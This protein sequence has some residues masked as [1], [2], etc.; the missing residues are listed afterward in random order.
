[1]SLIDAFRFKTSAYAA[2]NSEIPSVYDL[3]CQFTYFVKA[4]IVNIYSK[5]LTD[6]IQRTQGIS[7]K[8]ESALWDNC[9]ASESSK[10]LISL[11]AEAM[12]AKAELFL[13]YRLGVLRIADN[14]EAELIR[15]DYRERSESPLGLFISFK[16]YNKTDMLKIFS[17]MEYAV[18]NSLNKSMNL[19]AAVQFKMSK[20]RDSVG[21]IDSAQ[22]IAQARSVALAL[23]CGN[24][25]LLDKDDEI[26]TSS[27]EMESTKQAIAFL[28]SKRSFHL[29]LPTSYINGEQ[30]SGIGSTGEA[31][32]R[33]VERGLKHYYIS[34]VKPVLKALF[35]AKT[36]FKS[37]DFRLMGS[38]LEA[39]KTF[40]LVGEDML[41]VEIKRLLLARML[42]LDINQMPKGPVDD[43]PNQP[44]ANQ[45]SNSNNFNRAREV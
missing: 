27:P 7:E 31:D 41:T 10:G 38:A 37:E 33:A 28:D 25:V 35:G 43:A 22:V 39:L 44:P 1:M 19:S 29:N 42:D 26:Y 13:T 12:E 6:V 17:G 23:K 20:L 2:S 16:N 4:D 11:L 24:D 45:P 34:I 36:S 9:L 30:T 14:S 15:A 18:L 21:S 40:E 8:Y 32:T 5:I 3:N